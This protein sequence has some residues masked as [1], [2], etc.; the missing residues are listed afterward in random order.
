MHVRFVGSYNRHNL[1]LIPMVSSNTTS[2]S[3]ELGD[4]A[5][6]EDLAPIEAVWCHKNVP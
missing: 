6:S 1:I 2:F 3:L 4:P 5:T